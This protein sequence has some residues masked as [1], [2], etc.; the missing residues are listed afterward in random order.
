MLPLTA[1]PEDRRQVQ[2]RC[3][4]ADDGAGLLR[5]FGKGNGLGSV[6]RSLL[7]R[8]SCPE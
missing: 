8:S 4:V 2:G 5:E 6:M 7:L 3:K 1:I